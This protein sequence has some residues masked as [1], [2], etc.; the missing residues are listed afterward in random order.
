M[1]NRK[2]LLAVILAGFMS[3]TTA[4][5]TTSA[6][7]F[8]TEKVATEASSTAG[9]SED[10]ETD[11][12]SA[13]PEA[14][15]ENSAEVKEE[16][17]AQDS[18]EK[19]DVDKAEASSSSSSEEEKK[20]ELQ[21]GSDSS[22]ASSVSSDSSAAASS[23]S[24]D[25]KTVLAA[26]EAS[27]EAV[28][29]SEVKVTSI[30]DVLKA[31]SGE[32]TITGVVNYVSGKNVYVEDETGAICVYLS[33]KDSS[34]KV[35]N[36]LTATGSRADYNG[37]IELSGA[38]VDAN[39]SDNVKNYGFTEFDAANLKEL[40]DNHDSYECKKVVLKG[41]TVSS[42]ASSK[43]VVAG[44]DSSVLIYG[45]GT[46]KK[47]ENYPV[48]TL[49]N[50]TAVMS[51]YNGAQL[52]L[53]SDEEHPEVEAVKAEEDSE[54]VTVDDSI[55][56]NIA[57]FAGTALGSKIGEK[58]IYADEN[59]A[60][61][62]ADTGS[63]ISLVQ[64]ETNVSPV[65]KVS[66]TN[67][68][69]GSKG[70]VAGDYYQLQ[71][72][73]KGYGLYELDFSMKGSNTG[74][75]NWKVS[76][77]TDGETFV[78]FSTFTV[79]K[80]GQEYSV[81]LPESVVHVNNLLIRVAPSDNVA[82][83]GSEIKSGGVNRFQNIT[84][85][86]SPV[87]AGN[88]TNY[89]TVTP[90]SG[91]IGV[92]QEL[93]MESASE[94]AVIYYTV[95]GGEIK[96]YD[97]SSKPVLA[98]EDFILENDLD[99]TAQATVVAY[100]NTEEYGDSIKIKYVYTQTQCEAVKAS[101][102]GGAVKKNSLLTLK[103]ATEGAT[104]LY[105]LDA[106]E[107]WITY[108]E[109]FKLETLPVS[110]IAKAT[111]DG[112]VES[113]ATQFDFTE[114]LN[115][116]YNLYFGQLH[117]H[118]SYSDGAGTAEDA[119]LHASSEVENLDFLAVT[120]HSN[121]YDNDTSVNINDGSASSEWVEGHE[122][123]K[124]Y[125]SDEFVGIFGYE[126]TWSGG[127]PGHMNTFNTGGFM[128]RNMTGYESQSRVALQNYYA[129]LVNTPQS[130]SMFNHPGTTFGD[131]YDFAYYSKANDQQITL[132]EVGNGEGAIG[133]SGYF[134]SYEYYT[135]ALDKGW[136][137]APANN[138]DNHKGRWGDANTG[139]TVILADSLTEENIYDA[140]R[141]MRVYAT[142]DNDLN[143]YYTLNGEDMGTVLDEMPEKVDIKVKTS[144]VTDSSTMTV[145]VI[146]NGG[147]SVASKTVEE[148]E[149]ETTFELSPDYSYY[150][151]RITQADGDIAVTAPIWLSDVEAIGISSMS[152]DASLPVA[153]D[154]LNVSTVFYNNEAADFDVSSIVY[155]VDGEIIHTSDVTGDLDVLAPQAEVTDTFSYLCE[156][157]GKKTIDVTLLGYLNGVSKSYT[158]S[159]E[160]TYVSPDMVS[161]VII[162]GTHCNDYV[163]GYYGGNTGNFADIAADDYVKVEVVSTE[164][165]EEMLE[166]CSLLVISAPAKKNGTYSDKAYAPS[167]FEDSFVELVKKYVANGGNLILCGLADYQ[168]S[169][170]TQSSTEINKILEAIGA[171][172]RLNSDEMC[173]DEK[174][175]GQ[176]YRL[177][178]TEFNTDSYLLKGVSST[179][180]YSAYSGASVLVDEAA[181]AAG[182]AEAV[183]YGHESTY[184]IDSKKYDDNYVAVDKGNVVA[185]ARE[186]LAGGGEVLVAGTVFVS[187]FEVKSELDNYGSEYYA[188]RNILLNFLGN[189]QKTV[190]VSTIAELRQGN[191][192]DIFT[193]EGYVTAGTAVS[194]NKFFDTIYIQDETAGTT[195]FPIGDEGI[196]VG[197]KIRV[198]GYVDGYQ[199]DKEIQVYSYKILD[200]APY[201]FEP[202]QV[203]TKEASD[204]DALG[205]MLLKVQGKVTRVVTNS[206]GVDY[207]YV[208]DES[209]TEARVFIDGY[210]LASDGNDT[211]NEDVAVG[212][213]V[214]AVGL[215]YYNPDGACLRVRDRAE[216]ELV[217]KVPEVVLSIVE[218]W[219]AYYCVDQ[220]GNKVT[221]FQTLDG[222]TY[223]FNNK[224]AMQKS[225]W[226]TVDDV[227]YCA[228]SDGSIAK[229][230]K[231]TKWGASYIFDENGVLQTGFT[232][233]NGNT[234]Y[235]KPSNGAI[236][237]S[238][239]ITV[240]GKKYYAKDTG[241]LAKNETITKWG[242]K[243]SFDENGVLIK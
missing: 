41:V 36:L 31:E 112:Y 210:I 9:S 197:T 154:A 28:T 204:Y 2:R 207:F 58:I 201:V 82:I 44:G 152:I 143:I 87:K 35:G 68:I 216:I 223:Y 165:T 101:P 42:I 131:F 13:S 184:T 117:S 225:A 187:D 133:S 102:N 159:I 186:D 75:K 227:K 80:D 69:I 203:T 77:S 20:E 198:T 181:K 51:D 90:A 98:T 95:N 191:P 71:F 76:Y 135:R 153:G 239:W 220:D 175:G 121:Y 132:I 231:V 209:G 200:E 14:S 78:D 147:L 158:A 224:A 38:S 172:T 229:N 151:I 182:K 194:G 199:G 213:T 33:T 206:A 157:A 202:K 163:T 123:A 16:N 214:S 61:D 3:V 110:V 119:F 45:S 177:Y 185:L 48:G 236:Q 120:D 91:N 127:A 171:T 134:P 166:D 136:H 84:F 21:S 115:E 60:N 218:K 114:R 242:A 232:D 124:K 56:L 88:I 81:K 139:R 219:G 243:Y 25:E 190:D 217:E 106:G 70:M 27:S 54:N 155:S 142:E 148:S 12:E 164:I 188:N 11:G 193:V 228:L 230:M 6:V 57:S 97:A 150:Y 221:G 63:S 39:D 156:E 4:F 89:V 138:Q 107:N 238:T 141:N 32:F 26:T 83:N 205:G 161:H 241:I 170:N 126:M 140:I 146:V 66:D 52:I 105:S 109:P 240:D 15:S 46:G 149:G 233:F 195:V 178:F 67:V 23:V 1:K 30:A 22:E 145:E 128:S 179:Q 85:K 234:Y 173:D 129:Q 192:G 108:T 74:A 86:G 122:I 50:V 169:A 43:V 53:I 5:Q 196:E 208:V 211:V 226:I 8:A 118:T 72:N 111:C 19:N 125:T 113:V 100:A 17:I 59:A 10:G 103:T 189:H 55:V 73:S 24:S 104:I 92:G 65:Y 235:C 174:N 49:V 47:F 96:T 167:H 180:T 212:N 93:T 94:N 137:V 40:V 7:A 79:S 18:G 37:L 237:K 34:I 215:S 162:D 176:N 62:F 116:E 99:V 168:D 130:I 144:D 183:V 160:I 29:D 222:V 64:D